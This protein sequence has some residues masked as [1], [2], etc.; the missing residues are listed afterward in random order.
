MTDGQKCLIEQKR[1]I[2]RCHKSTIRTLQEDIERHKADIRRI[3][4][5]AGNAEERQG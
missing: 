5:E 2:I 3:K 4:E 1:E